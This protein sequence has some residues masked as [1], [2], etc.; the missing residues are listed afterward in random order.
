MTDSELLERAARALPERMQKL[1]GTIVRKA[2][3]HLWSGG[4][5]PEGLGGVED[6]HLLTELEH[7]LETKLQV[8]PIA[9][10][11]NADVA[12]HEDT[13]LGRRTM[14]VQIRKGKVHRT[15]GQ[16]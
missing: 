12:F 6:S 4:P 9:D 3:H 1:Q 2:G 10:A 14:V 11:D 5:V 15:I 7:L 8:E 16:A 13:P